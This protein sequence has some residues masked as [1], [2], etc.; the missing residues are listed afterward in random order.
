MSTD[1]LQIQ[2]NHIMPLSIT[3]QKLNTEQKISQLVT[4]QKMLHRFMQNIYPIAENPNQPLIKYGAK[5]IIENVNILRFNTCQEKGQ[6]F[7]LSFF[8]DIRSTMDNFQTPMISLKHMALYLDP[9]DE[10]KLRHEIADEINDGLAE[11]YPISTKPELDLLAYPT[12]LLNAIKNITK[13]IDYV[14]VSKTTQQEFLTDLT[15]SDKPSIENLFN[16]DAQPNDLLNRYLNELQKLF[17]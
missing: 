6:S 16:R 2:R 10:A 8:T 5:H 3:V 9:E 12:F 1:T 7:M 4:Y 17:V 15:E 11:I 13:V 14:N